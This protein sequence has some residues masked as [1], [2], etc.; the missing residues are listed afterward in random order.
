MASILHQS[1]IVRMRNVGYRIG[2]ALSQS[3]QSGRQHSAGAIDTGGVADEQEL[4]AC[5]GGLRYCNV[6]R[7]RRDNIP[8]DLTSCRDAGPRSAVASDRELG[9]LRTGLRPCI[10]ASPVACSSTVRYADNTHEN[11]T[12]QSVPDG[13]LQAVTRP[14]R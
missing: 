8:L 12:R 2:T 14:L 13:C 9:E 3:L 11:P 1:T 10:V 5:R 6:V 7:S 4:R